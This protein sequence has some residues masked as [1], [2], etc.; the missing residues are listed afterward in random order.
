MT[1]A[2]DVAA[3]GEE[4][5]VGALTR[6]KHNTTAGLEVNMAEPSTNEADAEWGQVFSAGE[7][8]RSFVE[9]KGSR[10]PHCRSQTNGLL[11]AH[12]DGGG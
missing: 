3:A 8:A 10:P 9:G 7:S 5:R 11:S 1:Q 6:L 4:T 12:L 2:M